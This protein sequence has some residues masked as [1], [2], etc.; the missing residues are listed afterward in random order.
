MQIMG[1]V[2]RGLPLLSA[3]PEGWPIIVIDKKDCFFSIPLTL[4]D[5]ERFAFTLPSINHEEPD[6]RY[7]WV[8]LPQGMA[9]SPTMCQIYVAAALEPVRKKFSAVR[10]LHYM[11]DILLA[12]KDSS[13]LQQAYAALTECLQEKGLVV[14]PEKVQQDTVVQYL[15]SRVTPHIVVPQK[16]ELRKDHLRTL[17]D[18]QKLLG[19]INWVRGSLHMAN[20]ELRPLYE[21]LNGDPALDSPR[22]LTLEA[23]EALI[24]VEE[25]LQRAFLQRIQDPDNI[26]LCILPTF[27]Q[28]TGL[29]W[30][31]RPLLWVFSKL[32]PAQTVQYYP[33]AVALLA[34][35]GIQQ[36]LQHFGSSPQNLIVPY[37]NHQ[38]KTL[39]ATV[40]GWAV[41][42]CSFTGIIDC[43]YPKHP[44]MGFFKEH[45][46]VFPKMTASQPI[47]GASIIFTDGSKTSVGAYIV[48]SDKPV[49]HQ[50]QPGTP[51]QVELQIVLEVFKACSFSFN[52]V[53]DSCYVVNALRNLECAGLIRSSSTVGALFSQLQ[54]LI[55][56]RKNPFFVQHIRAHTGLPGPLSQGN[57]M[58]DLCTRQEWMFLVS[59]VQHAYDFH[60]NFHVN[61]RTLQTKSSISS[62]D[63]RKVVLDCPQ[64]VV[65]HHLP[66]LGLNPRGLLPLKLWQM[67][68]TH[69]A[70]FGRLKYVHVS[71]DTCSGVIYTTPMVGEKAMHV[72]THCLEAWAAWGKPNNLKTDNGPAYTGS[73]F[74]SF[75][76]QLDVQLTHGLPYNPQGQGIVERAHRSLKEILQKQKGT[77]G[78]GRTPKERL[79]L[80]VLALN[81]LNMD[82]SGCS[83]ADRHHG[84]HSPIQGLVT[85]KD[86]LAGRWHGPDPVLTWARGSACVF[87]QDQQDPIWVPERLV[88]RAQPEQ[89]QKND[90][91]NM[92][93][94]SSCPA[95][96]D[97]KA[98]MGDPV[99]VSEA[100]ADTA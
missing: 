32:S 91:T 69:I 49:K 79:S 62:A 51:Q 63:P 59:A 70:E 26:T 21:I 89:T 25:R 90:S 87:P 85:W 2:Q 82:A 44:L 100:N 8:I 42:R 99:G 37:D 14:A 73:K 75:C 76:Q 9:N 65:F 28:P 77:I 7:Q 95:T 71:V 48:N 33:T 3:L 31:N 84:P 22:T 86:I 67:D 96:G 34:Q 29:M 53:S 17:N 24:K 93:D 46:V 47:F 45:P 4:K 19:D 11:D 36:C 13:L 94:I 88:R 12:A 38:V 64:C 18:F 20:H 92:P 1:P 40:D 35:Q 52:L 56:Q 80:A 50:F 83:S 58:V 72:I 41:L 10:C 57:H 97:D 61:A 74:T 66:S 16:V 23:R 81:F 98:E 78:Q 60:K 68:V 39:C 43:H 6:K 55:W 15:G 54:R 30:Q 5:S 27:S